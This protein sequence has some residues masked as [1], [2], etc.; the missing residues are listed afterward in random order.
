M[1]TADQHL[2]HTAASHPWRRGIAITAWRASYAY[3]VRLHSGEHV[4]VVPRESEWPGWQWCANAEGEEAWVPAVLLDLRGD[5]AT[6]LNDYDSTELD[7]R[8]GEALL[9]GDRQAGWVWCRSGDGSE[10]WLPDSC[11]AE[12]SS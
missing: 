3:T 12:Q 11:V 7:V 8:V 9:L 4:T 5:R 2:L 10:G 6:V 1:S